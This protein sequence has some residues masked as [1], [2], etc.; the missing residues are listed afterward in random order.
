MP[1]VLVYG[2]P[3]DT[4]DDRILA[5]KSAVQKA[6]ADIPAMRITPKQVSV[7]PMSCIGPECGE[8]HIEVTYNKK[9][10]RT[11]KIRKLIME[12]VKNTTEEYFK[13]QLC[14]VECWGR[15]F[16]GKKEGFA[17]FA[18]ND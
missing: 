17:W 8:I 12:T 7:M 9:W 14:L 16:N 10:R 5:Y 6:I 2:V 13:G 3:K 15:R 1:L 18:K 4:T 11:R